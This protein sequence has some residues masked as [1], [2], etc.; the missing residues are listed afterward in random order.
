MAQVLVDSGKQ[1]KHPRLEGGSPLTCVSHS[2]QDLPCFRSVKAEA[3]REGSQEVTIKSSY[4]PLAPELSPSV[5]DIIPVP[6]ARCGWSIKDSRKLYAVD[7]WGAPYFSISDQGHLCVTPQGGAWI[8]F[9][10]ETVSGVE[11]FPRV[12]GSAMEQSMSIFK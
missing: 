6:S 5:P 1:W 10:L 3:Y 2:W 9:V 12:I 4:E 8:P 7:G 11:D